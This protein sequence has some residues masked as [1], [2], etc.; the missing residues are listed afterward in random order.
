MEHYIAHRNEFTGSV[1][2]VKDHCENTAELCREY[3]VP[4]MKD[5]MY[6][7]GLLHDVGKFQASFVKRINGSDIRVEHST[8]GALAA[9]ENYAPGPMTLMMEYCIAGHHSGLPDGGFI[10]DS[11]DMVT[12][13]GRLKRKFEDFSEYRREMSLP[14]LDGAAWIRYLLYDCNNE[15]GKVIDKFAFLTRY[16]FS[17]LVDADSMDTADFCK[18][19]ELPRKLKADFKTCLQIA[20]RKLNSF[21]CKTELQ[22][23][24][25]YL[26][27][28]AFQNIHQD[29]E[30]YLLNMPT[31]SG[32]TLASIKIALERAIAKGKKRII[33]IIP[34][35]S[36]IEQT[37]EVF[38]Q[39]FADHMEILRHQS[40]F[41]YE[42]DTNGS[43]DYREA[44]KTAAEN[45]DAPFIITTAVQFFE[46]VY[47]NKRGKLRKMHNMSD[48]ILIFDEAHLMPQNYLQPCLQA[49]TYIT[50]YLHSEA[51]FLTAT[52]PDFEKL[53]KEYALPNSKIMTLIKDTSMFAV[54]QKC[55]YN[56]IGEAETSDLLLRSSEYPSS[57]IIVNKKSTAR[58]LYQECSGK[59]YHLST[60][61][62]SF[63]RKRV[64]K[65]IRDE[66]NQLENDYPD[67][68][69]IPDSRRITIIST[70]L[71][72]AGVD[73]DVYT[74]FRERSGLDSILQA[75]GRCN[76]EGKRKAADVYIFDFA[77]DTVQTALEEKAN[78][79][80]GLLNKYQNISDIQCISEY[81]SRLFFMKKNEIQE[82]TMH[83]ECSD[84]SSI[85]FKQYAEKF[86][87]IDS[88]TV[89]LVVPRDE[90]SEKLIE[91]M[92]YTARGNARKLQNYTCSL[93][94]KELEDLI[95]QHA[96]DDYGTGIYCLT[97]KDYYDEK[98]GI[99]FEAPDYFL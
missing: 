27:K 73:L 74:V 3:S 31:G 16:A 30:I 66:L 21:V 40:T 68:N 4:E 93:R 14:E 97:N 84:I 80:K 33:Y 98:K 36:I 71:I 13:Q 51:V 7:I 94:Q 39:L 19:K 86:E 63:D 87:L 6:V 45:W 46:S 75:G 32:K 43:E 37:A 99:L 2:T 28:Q 92:K 35:N 25:S 10:N 67:Y 44:A 12:L 82:N 54:F 85:P 38:E 90:Q 17:C 88:R 34:Y 61:M 26:Q 64:L 23:T 89:S 96:A 5:F 81:Y 65:E 91:E 76:R 70:S 8:C 15:I 22:K 55:R 42:D 24:R 11:S 1:Q 72:E 78:L 20:D 59:K 47:A 18:E 62:T 95:L 83:Q 58:N 41:S 69:N 77:N 9:R 50:R 60:Y 29:A 56:Y 49:V 57:L 53:I 52:M 48:S 79:T